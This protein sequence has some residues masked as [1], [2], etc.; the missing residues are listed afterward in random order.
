[1]L[2]V[3]VD[4]YFD[5]SLCDVRGR[6]SPLVFHGRLAEVVVAHVEKLVG[7]HLVRIAVHVGDWV[8]IGRHHIS[9]VAVV[10]PPATGPR[11][12]KVVHEA[13]VVLTSCQHVP[14]SVVVDVA[15][16]SDLAVVFESLVKLKVA[17]L[18]IVLPLV[19]IAYGHGQLFASC[20]GLLDAAPSHHDLV[21]GGLRVG[22]LL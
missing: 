8:Q 15:E 9:R 6:A 20:E 10:A 3:F 18:A 11:N 17:H 5:A 2:L 14:H 13:L 7:P 1:M 12:W 4:R 19:L 21:L 22:T 16:L